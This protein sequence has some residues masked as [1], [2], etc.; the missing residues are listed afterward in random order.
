MTDDPEQI[1]VP[2][3]KSL[4]MGETPFDEAII[5]STVGSDLITYVPIRIM[6]DVLG[7]DGGYQI[8]VIRAHKN[9]RDGLARL[10]FLNHYLASTRVNV[11]YGI[12]VKKLHSW[13][14]TIPVESLKN[15]D[16]QERLYRMQAELS[17]VLYAW[18]AREGVPEDIRAE[19]EQNL[20]A[21]TQNI[22]DAIA[23]AR[24]AVNLAELALG[25]VDEQQVTLEDLQKRI[26]T[27]ETQWQEAGAGQEHINALQK[28]QYRS[29]VK[30][31]GAQLVKKG[32]G[33]YGYVETELK[34]VF[35]FNS[36]H[37]IAPDQFE[38]IRKY[39]IQWYQRL[40]PKGTPLPDSF[41]D[42]SQQS[43]F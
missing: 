10:P 16:A 5:P 28:E 12:S 15:P 32:Q 9:L 20:P 18:A 22:Y 7:I 11:M 8:E 14:M 17:E 1:D 38:A 19:E 30:L 3:L 24:D 6:C 21:E 4:R 27:L 34:R 40:V 31:I 25:K 37:W 13:L 36:Y 29:W 43:L 2:E 23:N 26:K 35:H 33:D 41:S 42:P 39:C